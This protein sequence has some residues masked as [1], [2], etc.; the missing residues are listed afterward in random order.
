M[1][2]VLAFLLTYRSFTTPAYLLDSCIHRFINPP[3][4]KG[5]QD[6]GTTTLKG[7]IPLH[8]AQLRYVLILFIS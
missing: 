3:Q 6:F 8:P 7:N 2:Y 5:S 4:K 1:D